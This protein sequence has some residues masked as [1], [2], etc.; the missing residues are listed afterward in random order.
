M[1]RGDAG[2]ICC[3]SPAFHFAGGKAAVF[4]VNN[5]DARLF[6]QGLF[7]DFQRRV[8]LLIIDLQADA[9]INGTDFISNGDGLST[10]FFVQVNDDC[11]RC[12][13]QNNIDGIGRGLRGERGRKRHDDRKEIF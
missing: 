9:N 8:F 7:D 11:W 10:E 5:L 4:P 12:L 2:S 3:R 1:I 6:G 13:G